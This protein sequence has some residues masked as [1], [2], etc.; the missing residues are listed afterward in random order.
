MVNTPKTVKGFVVSVGII[1]AVVVFLF[2]TN[3]AAFVVGTLI[4]AAVLYLLY[5]IGV[6]GHQ[7][8]ING[9]A[10]GGRR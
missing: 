8:A 9:R 5:V 7:Y 6:R 3:L 4:V 1:L 2:T 10:G